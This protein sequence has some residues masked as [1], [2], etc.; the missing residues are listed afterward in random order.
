MISEVCD[1]CFGN[2]DF[3]EIKQ[4]HFCPECGTY[5]P[6]VMQSIESTDGIIFSTNQQSHEKQLVQTTNYLSSL[7]SNTEDDTTLIEINNMLKCFIESPESQSS[8]FQQSFLIMIL[9][10]MLCKESINKNALSPRMKS[11]LPILFQES[12]IYSSRYR[13]VY[14]IKIILLFYV[15]LCFCLEI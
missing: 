3:D 15:E 11:L 10:E 5:F 14:F 6:E 4:I 13:Y 2:L 7:L 1:E 8:F 9:S 12:T